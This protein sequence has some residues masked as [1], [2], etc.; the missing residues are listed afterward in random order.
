MKKVILSAC[1]IAF[2]SITTYA[3]ALSIK[4]GT[5]GAYP[6]FNFMDSDGN[7]GGF[8]VEIGN[9]LC[10]AMGA[11]CT[12]ITSDWDGIIPAL[13]AKKF[14]T[15][16]ASMSITDERKKKI[17]FTNKYY[18]SPVKFIRLKGKSY[19]P[20]DI[21]GKVVG[22]Q[23]GTVTDDFLKATFG[24]SIKLK[25]YKTQDEANLDLLNGRLDL[26]AADGAV[27]DGFLNSPKGKKV[28]FVGKNY[29]DKEILGEGIGIG[30]RKEDNDLREKLNAAIKEIRANGT[31]QKINAKYF[32]F[33]IY[34]E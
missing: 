29:N 31:Y 28:E 15:I 32:N 8:D 4:M 6:P 14:D 34:G 13:Q 23:G 10:E 26:V 11:E 7:P 21:K 16:V 12:W 5:E 24:K 20:E 3:N 22:T 30:V 1:F 25:T 33:D 27:L 19:T 9:A 17:N 18:S 2:I